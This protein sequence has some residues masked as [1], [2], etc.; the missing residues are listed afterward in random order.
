MEIIIHRINKVSE[1][2][3]IPKRYG[4]EIDLRAKGSKIIL[5]H[6]PFASGDL[7]ENYLEFYNHGTVIVN[8]KEA[9]IEQAVIDLLNT[10]KIK[11]Y[12]LL[13]VEMPFVYNSSLKNFKNI[14]IRFSEY[15][16]IINVKFFLGKLNWV[17]IDTVTS[18]PLNVYNKKI[19]EQFHSCLVCPERWGRPDDIFLYYKKLTRLSFFPSAVM[20]SLECSKIWSSL[21]QNRLS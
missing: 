16:N 2:L 3:K 20:T 1:L 6:E 4:V 12:F 15:E 19:I 7:F 13:D 8:I 18:L 14:A 11:K 10:Y 5:N 21:L 9:G 17:W